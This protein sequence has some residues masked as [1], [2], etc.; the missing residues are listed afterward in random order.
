LLGAKNKA[1]EQ[2]LSAGV[3]TNT[4]VAG[5]QLG[6]GRDFSANNHI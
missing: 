5:A 3:H 1:D 6:G 2:L 4:E